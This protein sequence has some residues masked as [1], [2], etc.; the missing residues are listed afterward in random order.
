[1]VTQV[2][3]KAEVSYLKQLLSL[4]Q[5]SIVA[6]HNFALKE[7]RDQA[8]TWLGEMAIPTKKDED[9]QFTDLSSL[10]K[11]NFQAAKPVQ[12]EREYILPLILPEAKQSCLVFVDGE[13]APDLSTWT[14]EPGIFAG[15][16]GN[17]PA[18]FSEKINNY[19]AKTPGNTEIFTALNTAALTDAAIIWVAKNTVVETPLHLL[20]IST[21]DSAP[22]F[23]Q[24]RV[25]VVAEAGSALNFIEHYAS[26]E[27]C[28]S[29]PTH[30]PYFVNSVTE[31]WVEEN[32]E[33]KHTRVQRDA[34]IAFHI[35]RSAI[36]QA[37]NSR[38]TLNAV[39][40]GAKLSRHTL[41]VDQTGEGTETTL[42]GLTLIKE[43]QLADTHSSTL[44]NHPHGIYNQL[45]KC[46][47]DDRARGVFNGRVVVSQAAQLTNANQLS[48]NLL[49]SSHARINTKPQLEIVAD[50]VK[51]SHGA[52]VSQLEDDEIF[53]LRSRGLDDRTSRHLL[54]DAF[55]SEILQKLPLDSLQKILSRCVAC[56]TELT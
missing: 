44:F 39:S 3:E 8:T 6:D 9:W 37:R 36:S 27:D 14:E 11:V 20:L 45:H 52:T 7:I 53:Y 2:Q 5:K 4:A 18:S 55:A 54:I 40:L 33:V 32:A 17:L 12:L 42:N 48:Q 22:R 50:D 13:Y 10:L 47:L 38:Y 25:L 23:S 16:L 41:D 31:I 35:G 28:S 43:E 56:R 24:P 21:A 26:L 46:I 51:C 30:H 1:M 34:A 19:L 49:L 29:T 15:N